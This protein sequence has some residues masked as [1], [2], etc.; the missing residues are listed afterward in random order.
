MENYSS[1]AVK[2]R[3]SNFKDIIGQKDITNFLQKA[4][5]INKIPHTI[6]FYGNKG[7]GKTSCARIFSK[8]VNCI[9]F[10]KSLESCNICINCK[11]NNINIK[12]IDAASNN[13][14]ENIRN[15]IAQLNYKPYIGNY[16][17]YIIDE[18]HMLSQSAF[19]ALLK[20][21]E[22]PPNHVIFILITTEKYKIIPTVLSRCQIFEFK[23]ISE[24]DIIDNL[25]IIALKE[26]FKIK[27]EFFLEIA[28]RCDGSFRDSLFL[29]DKLSL[30]SNSSDLN[31]QIQITNKHKYIFLIK[32]ICN[33][34]ITKSLHTLNEL[35]YKNT[36]YR[37]VIYMLTTH[38][39]NMLILFNNKNEDICDFEEIKF[40][41]LK[42]IKLININFIINAIKIMHECDINY[43]RS[44]NK[45]L[46]IEISIIKICAF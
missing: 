9:N 8:S 4:I 2:Y 11:S 3:P 12:E 19:N 43:Y 22:E 42:L 1:L 18:A 33:K 5:Q 44:Y 32:N 40:H 39:R 23:T 24:K 45:K 14:V 29:L 15:I 37:Y 31:N 46:H 26:N 13:S 16:N 41:Y 17:I 20:T 6:L 34:D 21:I 28:N 7:I 25:K 27:D 30:S 38:I 10:T 35:L 36:E